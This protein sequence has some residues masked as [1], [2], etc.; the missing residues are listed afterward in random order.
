M[1][2]H[3]TEVLALVE[4]YTASDIISVLDAAL[5]WYGK[6]PKQKLLGYGHYG[7]IVLLTRDREVYDLAY[8][9]L[10]EI[11]GGY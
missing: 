4:R 5:L 3:H 1:R 11:E 10:Q 9:I 6:D 2:T 8:D 7:W